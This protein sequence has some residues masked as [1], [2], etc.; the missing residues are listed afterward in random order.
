MT[1]IFVS[2]LLVFITSSL[3]AQERGLPCRDQANS[4]TRTNS[5]FV[6]SESSD[7]QASRRLAKLQKAKATDLYIGEKRGLVI[8][9]NFADL[10]MVSETAQADFDAQFNEEGYS[11]SGHVGSVS[12]YFYEQ[13]YEQFRLR[14]DVVG[15]ITVSQDM[16]YYGGNDGGSDQAVCTLVIEAC[17]MVDELVDFS[18]YDWDGDN[19]VDQVF[20]I[21]AGYG[22]NF[23]G[24]SEDAIWPH[25]WDL[26]SGKSYGDGTGALTLDGVKIDTYAMS[27]ELYGKS[28]DQMDGIG[29]ACHEFAHCLG[30]P[31]FYDTSYKGGWGMQAGD[32]MDSG[33]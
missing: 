4:Q 1:R 10:A 23:T 20:L 14:F 24:V 25:E 33:C 9:V 6:D 7:S 5:S 2:I 28:G 26:S 15:P 31:D 29:M 22:E 21:Y 13:S 11:K 27:C 19:E 16:A 32:L 30:Y 18:D 12:D 3:F 17:K 8:L